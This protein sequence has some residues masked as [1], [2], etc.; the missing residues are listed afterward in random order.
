MNLKLFAVQNLLQSRFFVMFYVWSL[1][2]FPK[3]RVEGFVKSLNPMLILNFILFYFLD[4]R[5]PSQ[6]VNSA[7]LLMITLI[8]VINPLHIL[9]D[10]KSVYFKK[11]SARY[12]FQLR[13]ILWP[14]Y[15]L[16]LSTSFSTENKV[17]GMHEILIVK[18]Y[19]IIF[20]N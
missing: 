9:S 19:L 10:S 4:M 6:V 5:Q 16:F 1:T 2:S 20:N 17:I 14:F 7:D 13:L 12:N 3:F 18:R 11:L 15:S 8:C